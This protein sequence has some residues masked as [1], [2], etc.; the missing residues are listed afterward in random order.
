VKHSLLLTAL[1]TIFWLALS[2]HYD[3]LTLDLGV[4]SIALVMW[5]N[6]KMHISD[7]EVLPPLLLMRL[8]RYWIWLLVEIVKSNI[9]V[10]KKIWQPRLDIQPQFKKIPSPWKRDV[11]RVIHANSVTLTPGT[12]TVIVDK[13][14]LLVHSLTDETMQG[15]ESPEMKKR[16][17]ML[18]NDQ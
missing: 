5:L 6:W 3:A 10:A 8:P 15:L 7:E 14:S 13:D 11:T 4:L 2:G 16:L 9:H 18:E 1:L 12:V 17:E